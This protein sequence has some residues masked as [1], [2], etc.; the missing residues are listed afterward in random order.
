MVHKN[1]DAIVLRYVGF[2][3]LFLFFVAAIF[4][5]RGILPVFL[6]AGL[7]AFAL[8]PV[9]QRLEKRGRSRLRAVGFVFVILVLIGLILLSLLAA[10]FQQGQTLAANIGTYNDQVTHLIEIQRQRLENSKLPVAVKQSITEAIQSNLDGARARVPGMAADFAARALAGAGSFFFNLF[11]LNLITL[12]LMLEAHRI[13]ARLLMLVP[14]LYRRDV[15]ELSTS[16][17]ELLGRY[18][19]GQAIVCLSFGALCTVAFEVLSRV[20]GLQYPL[21]LGAMAAVV[22][23]LPYFGLAVIMVTAV[24]TA[25][26]TAAQPL[27]CA[28]ATFACIVAINLATD[29]GISPRVLGKGVGLHPLL[30]IFALVCGF[31]VGG[32]LGT[33][34]AVPLF[35]S[36]GVI[37]IYLFPQLAAP[38]PNE[39]IFH[40]EPNPPVTKDEMLSD[41]ARAEDAAPDSPIRSATTS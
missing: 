29:Y 28:I 2:G 38:I 18:V 5:I 34:V 11:L 35:A 6:G 15:I 9:L 8:E 7:V 32:P 22:Y 4:L 31:E 12:G 23:V 26:L 19:R 27:P 40:D 41:V 20:Y 21:I 36:L 16:I 14:P 33:L 39:E 10:A 25:Y 24:A 3:L 37:A 13:K 17:N 1:L 30:V